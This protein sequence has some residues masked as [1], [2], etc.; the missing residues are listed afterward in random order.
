M[1]TRLC[2]PLHRYILLT[3][4]LVALLLPVGHL[5]ADEC[6]TP[7]DREPIVL[8]DGRIPLHEVFETF[9]VHASV[10]YELRGQ[11][12][13]R[14]F[15]ADYGLDPEMPAVRELPSAFDA[16]E[17]EAREEKHEGHLA[18]ERATRVG[19]VLARML[20]EIRKSD[21]PE[22]D[23][24]R[25]FRL[26]LMTKLRPEMSWIFIDENPDFASIDDQEEHFNEALDGP[27]QTPP[28][29]GP[30]VSAIEGQD[31]NFQHDGDEPGAPHGGLEPAD[32]PT[33]GGERH[34]AGK[35]VKLSFLRDS[36]PP[37]LDWLEDVGAVQSAEL[38]W[39][40][41][42]RADGSFR[43][44][45]LIDRGTE[46]LS[47]VDITYRDG[48]PLRAE[49]QRDGVDGVVRVSEVVQVDG[50]DWDKSHTSLGCIAASV[51]AAAA[52]TG[53]LVPP[54]PIL[55]SA[56]IAAGILAGIAC[57]QPHCN[58][59][60]CNT[61]CVNACH[62]YGWC[63][64][65]S[66]TSTPLD[67][68]CFG[69]QFSSPGCTPVPAPPC[70]SSVSQVSVLGLEGGDPIVLGTE[71]V[72]LDRLE[73]SSV[74]HH[75][76]AVSY[77]MG[78]WAVLAYGPPAL[79][80]KASPS[81]RAL[82][83]SSPEFAAA[84]ERTLGPA[85]AKGLSP[86][87]SLTD[88]VAIVVA[89]PPHEA[90]SRQI[91]MPSLRVASEG[92]PVGVGQGKVAIRADFSEAGELQELEILHDTLGGVP[93]RLAAYLEQALSL[94]RL[95]SKEHRVVVFAVLSVGNGLTIESSLSYLPKCCCGSTFCV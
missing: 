84:Q 41:Y 26:K 68:H 17:R 65:T 43:A 94:Q 64:D 71:A 1:K 52:C 5:A 40:K 74:M 15:L 36:D 60:Q 73:K 30:M 23:A 18:A 3:S 69:I 8:R 34:S 80:T 57:N 29:Q 19:E 92:L 46:A 47:L 61:N 48:E 58:Q 24:E 50:R 45:G 82:A 67:C 9:L 93:P 63:E 49:L 85:L 87:L 86:S 38:Q 75:G 66:G 91:P 59:T 62:L 27:E 89:T 31:H 39:R 25:S 90:N 33:C 28:G 79:A 83:S 56:C 10:L 78:E 81:A 2:R 37:P 42:A 76:E 20:A 44:I 35:V 12:A 16:L 14:A 4:F 11:D 77:L 70:S 32:S 55:C 7:V 51:A 6:E 22:R 88:A 54:D 53:C 13:Y 21:T 95:S 72:A